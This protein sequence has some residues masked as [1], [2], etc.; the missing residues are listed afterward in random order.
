MSC[1]VQYAQALHDHIMEMIIHRFSYGVRALV[2]YQPRTIIRKAILFF[3]LNLISPSRG[4]K[5]V[6][7][8]GE[9]SPQKS[10]QRVIY[11]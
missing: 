7:R 8:A 2:V 10:S 11:F 5:G 4:F 9:K 1:K 3:L 6:R